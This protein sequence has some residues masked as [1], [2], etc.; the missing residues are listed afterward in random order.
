MTQN[1]A[2]CPE[3]LS[4]LHSAN[5]I[6]LCT[7]IFPDGDAIGSALALALA[8]ESLGKRVT[9]SCA[10]PVPGCYRFLP[11]ADRFVLPD[12]LRRDRLFQIILTRMLPQ[13]FAAGAIVPDS[14]RDDR[15]RQLCIHFRQFHN[16]STSR[17]ALTAS[18]SVSCVFSFFRSAVMMRSSIVFSVTM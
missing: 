2:F 8:L 4:A 3:M 9:V 14:P 10:D 12:T 1:D 11:G 16:H 18:I 17:F 15:F 6:L 13:I 5:S 7:H